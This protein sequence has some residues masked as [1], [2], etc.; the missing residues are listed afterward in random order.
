VALRHNA[1]GLSAPV[2][3]P[4]G[5]SIST[6]DRPFGS[7]LSRAPKAR[8][9]ASTVA[10]VARR[11]GFPMLAGLALALL[12]L[13]SPAHALDL[14]G[15]ITARDHQK[16]AH[17]KTKDV[18]VTWTLPGPLRLGE[19]GRARS[20]AVPKVQSFSSRWLRT[21]ESGETDCSEQAFVGWAAGAQNPIVHSVFLAMAGRDHLTGRATGTLRLDGVSTGPAALMTTAE[22]GYPPGDP[23]DARFMG[24]DAQ[25]D[26]YHFQE[27]VVGLG[28]LETIAS[29]G[30]I[31]NMAASEYLTPGQ[32]RFELWQGSWRSKGTRTRTGD[33]FAGIFGVG[34]RTVT[35]S[36]D[37]RSTTP[38]G[39]CIAPKRSLV[40]G[41]TVAHV[42]GLLRRAKLRPGRVLRDSSARAVPRGRVTGLSL[43]APHTRAERCG[44]S[45][46]IWVR[47]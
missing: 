31:R 32:V 44:A 36:W 37:L 11:C 20:D 14:S 8:G 3:R 25:G 38:T 26:G 29:D 6:A 15:T 7:F 4:F 34:T 5:L 42:K 27:T 21:L 24:S 2:N 28:N 10:H 35:V 47:S 17:G 12:A 18:T 19:S 40:R 22:C 23:Y 41:K 9:I 45:I 13:A 43:R 1:I 30:S 16:S 39:H 33:Y 46:P